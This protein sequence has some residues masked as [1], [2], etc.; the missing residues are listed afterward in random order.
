MMSGTFSFCI[1]YWC[2]WKKTIT[3]YINTFWVKLKG[4]AWLIV[5]LTGGSKAILFADSSSSNKNFNEALS[6]ER[7]TERTATFG[8][9]I[10]G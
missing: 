4:L 1:R 9:K 2:I 6:A 10:A 3:I 7:V 5:D 8:L